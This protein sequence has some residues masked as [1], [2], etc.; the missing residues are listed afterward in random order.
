KE[1]SSLWP[2]VAVR[3][4]MTIMTLSVRTSRL[5]LL[6]ACLA[7]AGWMLSLGVALAEQLAGAAFNSPLSALHVVGLFSK[8]LLTLAGTTLLAVRIPELA[9]AARL[10][11]TQVLVLISFVGPAAL[12]AGAIAHF[13]VAFGYWLWGR[14]PIWKD[15][16]PLAFA[17][18]LLVI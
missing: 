3:R 10:F 5:L 1:Y 8:P 7:Y 18:G 17:C 2:A 13:D 16:W 11:P 6:G 12:W 9:R 15:V 4:Q 14:A